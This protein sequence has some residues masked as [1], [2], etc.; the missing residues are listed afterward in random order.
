MSAR[1]EKLNKINAELERMSDE[2]LDHVAG[3]IG[4]DGCNSFGNFFHQ[5]QRKRILHRHQKSYAA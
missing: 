3:G 2:E 4:R 1:E 5:R